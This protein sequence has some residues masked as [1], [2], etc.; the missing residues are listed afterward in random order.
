MAE[1]K[2]SKEKE[3]KVILERNYNVPL[4]KE[5]LKAPMHKRAKKAIRGLRIFIARHMKADE[6]KNVKVERWANEKIWSRGTTNP[7]HHISVITK[8]YDDG[9]VRVELAELSEH[10]KRTEA[11]EKKMRETIKGKAKK[12]EEKEEKK[13]EIKKEESKAEKE[14]K[15]E[16][17]EVMK[18]ITPKEFMHEHKHAEGHAHETKKERG[19]SHPHRMTLEK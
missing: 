11:K 10:A 4:R 17:K 13:E 9:T 5:W 12:P 8:K 16:E 15:K 2:K 19:P 1:E 18:D 6:M 3:A 7:P 14:V